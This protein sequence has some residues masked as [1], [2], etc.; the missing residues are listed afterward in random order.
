MSGVETVVS[1]RRYL[2]TL[3]GAACTSGLAGC[4][5][6]EGGEEEPMTPRESTCSGNRTA[7]A[8]LYDEWLLRLRP[9]EF[10]GSKLTFSTVTPP[11]FE[12]FPEIR[13]LTRPYLLYPG[14]IADRT[15]LNDRSIERMTTL[16]APGETRAAY[17]AFRSPGDETD[18][19]AWLGE[20]KL[21]FSDGSGGTFHISFEEVDEYRG[22][23]RHNVANF[24]PAKLVAYDDEHVVVVPNAQGPVELD[25][26]SRFERLVATRRGETPPFHCFHRDARALVEQLPSNDLVFAWIKTDSETFGDTTRVPD[27][28]RAS[29][30]ALSLD[31][32]GR[33]GEERNDLPDEPVVDLG[34]YVVFPEGSGGAPDVAEYVRDHRTD[35]DGDGG[36]LR[37]RDPSYARQG[38][39]VTVH[40]RRPVE[41]I[42]G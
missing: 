24:P 34:M 5:M 3:T 15:A 28:A 33:G 16:R 10:T 39:V 1:R 14:R 29:A 40:E 18:R 19:R 4:G 21:E 36:D 38:R 37:F 2:E 11:V 31:W 8:D 13:E 7:A 27:G 30:F 26:E 20:F 35:A 42:V 41:T 12:R 23:H 9:S 22:W 6:V 32:P 25:V 17:V